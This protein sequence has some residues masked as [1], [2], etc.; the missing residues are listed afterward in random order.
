MIFDIL[1]YYS[2]LHFQPFFKAWKK[3]FIYYE[4]EFSLG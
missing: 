1:L 3:F 2:K 4:K